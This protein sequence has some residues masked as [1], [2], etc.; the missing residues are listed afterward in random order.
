MCSPQPPPEKQPSAPRLLPRDAQSLT[1]DCAWCWLARYGTMVGWPREK[2]G[3]IC[4]VHLESEM[5]R[6]RE[7]RSFRSH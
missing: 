7:R 6:L 5:Q 3:D 1:S 2:S 4:Q